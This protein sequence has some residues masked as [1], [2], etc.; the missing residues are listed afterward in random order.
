[1]NVQGDRAVF[2]Q[3]VTDSKEASVFTWNKEYCTYQTTVEGKGEYCIGNYTTS[4]VKYT[5]LSALAVSELGS[6]Q[7]HA[8]VP[9]ILK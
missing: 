1:M 3:P 7:F 9:Y 6:E 8:A 2:V 4:D 5:K